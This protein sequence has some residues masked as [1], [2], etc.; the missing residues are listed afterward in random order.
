M[1]SYVTHCI[2]GESKT[3]AVPARS[4][5]KIKVG[6]R[7]TAAEL[8]FLDPNV[9][10]SNSSLTE[11]SDVNDFRPASR[12][13]P[14][15]PEVR[16]VVILDE[17]APSDPSSQPRLVEEGSAE[18][19]A[20]RPQPRDDEEEQGYDD[21]GFDEEYWANEAALWGTGSA[22]SAEAQEDDREEYD[23]VEEGSIWLE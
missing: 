4:M 22:N 16:Q 18:G 9:E 13:S 10:D 11:V 6:K 23:G 2:D 12:V 8:R 20:S 5:R 17:I 3:N 15:V 14:A 21:D 7:L 1:G 19:P